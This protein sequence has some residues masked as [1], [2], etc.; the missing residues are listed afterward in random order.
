MLDAGYCILSLSAFF[1][2][3]FRIACVR[4]SVSRKK[5]VLST[6][7]RSA[8]QATDSTCSGWSANSAATKALGQNAPD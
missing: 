2:L 6:S 8:T 1:L 3:S 5:N 4:H 7:L